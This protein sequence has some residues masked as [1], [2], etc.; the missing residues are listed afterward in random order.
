M[1]FHRKRR[2]HEM[3]F[4]K[5][6]K[7]AILIVLLL[8][9]S[10]STSMAFVPNVRAHSPPL[11]IP[12]YAFLNVAPNPAGIGQ[13]VTVD[14]WL[15]QVP[16][17]A[18]AQYGDRWMN[19]KVTVTKPDGTNE[20]LGPF[21][22]DDTGGFATTYTPTAIGNYTFVFNFLGQT[23]AGNNPAPGAPNPYIGDYYEP[24]TSESVTITVQQSPVP[25]IP[26]APIP[27]SYW[28]RPIE[29][30]N[31]NWY[32]I[33]GNWLGLGATSFGQT[34]LY[35]ATG[36]YNPYTTAPTTS[37]IIWTKPAAWGGLVGGEFGGT[38]TSN[39]YSTSQYEPKF[40]PI[41][42]N[43]VL[44][45][46]NF[47][48]ASTNPAGWT[49][50]NLQTGQT[51]WTE[52]TLNNLL[53]GQLLNYVSPNQYGT[54]GYLWA[55]GNP[56]AGVTTIAAAINIES[57]IEEYIPGTTNLPIAPGST[58]LNMYDAMT[59][60]Y[61]L[62]IINAPA[63]FLGSPM[64][65]TED[66]NGDLI[67]YYVNSTNANAPTLN[68]WN[69][70]QAILYPT[71]K[72]PGAANWAW[73][74]PQNMAIQFSAGIMWS[75][76]LPTNINGVLLPGAL[77][78]A[79]TILGPASV[80]S[81]VILLIAG[82]SGTGYN[83]GFQIEAGFSAVTGQQLW[84]V[85][86]TETSYTRMQMIGIGDGVYA[87]VNLE[88]STLVG[89]SLNSGKQLWT[90]NLPSNPYNSIGGYFSVLANNELYLWGFG[91]DIWSINMQTG[92]INWH[93]T[94]TQLIGSAGDNTPYGVWPLWTFSV[95]TVAG[96]ILYVPMGHEYSPPLF[97]GA[98]QLAINTT[99]G[100][101][102]WSLMACDV[103]S[104][105]AI[106]D[107][108]MTTLNAYDN[109]IYAWGMGPSET[110]VT[111]PDIGVTTAAPI[112]I[113]GSVMDISAG[114]SQQAVAANFPHGLPCVS[115]ASMSAFM[116]AVYEQQAMPTNITG[117]PVALYVL[118]SNNNYRSIGTTTTDASGTFSYAWTPDVSG[119]YTIYAT[120]AG[121]GSYYGS[122]AETHIYASP[123]ATAATPTATPQTGLASNTTVEY[124]GVAII[125]VI[126]II[127]AAILMVVTRKHP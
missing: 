123:A 38:G 41:I 64:T 99:D 77:S 74:P 56:P 124:I 79:N 90:T 12:S 69:S 63:A 40:A 92:A 2:N 68:C 25:S 29:S 94:T 31:D 87:W 95:G 35:N 10:M 100:S 49:A 20:T 8:M 75:V 43:G 45:Y 65:L 18:L 116:E 17:T 89:Y 13:T 16:P 22:S 1:Q 111:A 15:G 127:G 57:L 6:K 46:E 28:S 48:G 11:Q 5:S 50:V 97:R 61:V 54:I 93:T 47:P 121:T 42:I 14:M 27:T 52:N 30:V 21:T 37:H 39:F 66:A 122:S 106:S 53:C 118:D 58:T 114:A 9:I 96:G 24:A 81:G 91:G 59:G 19:Y 60:N 101:L 36:D 44:Y 34:G 82:G 72:T 110:S 103:T 70:T 125:V 84:I 62:S 113:T 3:K 26:Q 109:Q 117:V 108:I 76:P 4:V 71:G 51:L 98:N 23:L 126:V 105:P 120:F 119:N 107:G 86:R 112:T 85:N 73:R 104:G 32:T 88:T 83:P 102:V 33:S 7:S 115:D 67:G 55:T 80:N 78:L